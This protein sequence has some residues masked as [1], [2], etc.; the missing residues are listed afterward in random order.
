MND[1]ETLTDSWR[2]PS[3]RWY[4]S[5]LDLLP[6]W[7][8]LADRRRADYYAHRMADAAASALVGEGKLALELL[9]RTKASVIADRIARGRVTYLFAALV[10]AFGILGVCLFGAWIS[11]ILPIANNDSSNWKA[12]TGLRWRMGAIGAFG[13]LFSI[14]I[15]LRDRKVELDVNGRS[16]FI[17]ATIRLV[18]GAIAGTVMGWLIFGQ[19]LPLE[20]ASEQAP[21]PSP[22]GPPKAT[23]VN[24]LSEILK[25]STSPPHQNLMRLYVFAFLAGFAERLVPDFLDRLTIKQQGGG[26]SAVPAAAVELPRGTETSPMGRKAETDGTVD[27]PADADARNSV[28]SEDLSDCC[29]DGVSLPPDAITE[30]VELPPAEGGVAS[31]EGQQP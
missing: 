23:N 2:Y 20:L 30:D 13:A 29:G 16:N 22:E 10:I 19:M 21:M 1:I 17:D 24:P 12:L 7:D 28:E 18:V 26:Q 5:L 8:S 31:P 25:A 4:S 6:W 3:A 15:G 27:H 9:D 14:A 11:G